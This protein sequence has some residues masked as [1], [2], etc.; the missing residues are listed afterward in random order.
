MANTDK[1]LKKIIAFREARNWKQFNNPKDMAISLSL[2]ALE[3]LEHFQW[4]SME[5][6]DKY[7]K[8]HK[9][10]IGEELADVLY[11]VVLLS[12]DMDIDLEKTF[13]EKMKKNEKK[14]PARHYKSKNP[15][16]VK[17]KKKNIT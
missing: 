2:E 13:M 7:V 11:W 5:E 8:S 16:H 14:Y 1:I 15:K 4:I 12:H 10:E 3:V 17:R 9:K 6:M